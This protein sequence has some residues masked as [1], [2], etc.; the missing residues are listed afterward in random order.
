MSDKDRRYYTTLIAIL[1][2]VLVVAFM[3]VQQGHIANPFCTPNWQCSSWTQCNIAGVQ[4]RTCTDANSCGSTT[5]KPVESQSCTPQ[6][7]AQ[8]VSPIVGHLFSING[9][10]YDY[11]PSVPYITN[12]DVQQLR[13]NAL[14][15]IVTYS[16]YADFYNQYHYRCFDLKNEGTQAFTTAQSATTGTS[17]RDQMLNFRSLAIDAIRREENCQLAINMFTNVQLTPVDYLMYN[18]DTLTQEL[19]NN[20]KISQSDEN[21]EY[22]NYNSVAGNYNRN[23]K[24]CN[25]AY[26]VIGTD[27]LCY[28]VCS[29]PNLYCP[30]GSTCMSSTCYAC[31]PGFTLTQNLNCIQT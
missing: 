14:G 3:V 10:T 9:Q 30:S 21:I 11:D 20:F 7:A 6:T 4:T 26:Q 31:L 15:T 17:S 19:N 29:T 23:I 18:I 5:N 16:S 2:A 28:N 22:T 12:N 13:Q 27:G 8:I 25:S 24:S 1:G